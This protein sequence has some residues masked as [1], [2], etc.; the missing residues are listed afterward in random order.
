MEIL[1]L[2][3][4]SGDAILIRF[5]DV[6]RV[7]RHILVDGGNRRSDY[8]D[9]L[10]REMEKIAGSGDAIDLLVATHQDQDHVKGLQ[11]L[12][13]DL[14][15]GQITGA[16]CS[17]IRRYWFNGPALL[18]RTLRD[19]GGSFEDISAAEARDLER[20]VLQDLKLGEADPRSLVHCPQEVDLHGA[21]LT[22]L[23]PD[24]KALTN[25]ASQYVDVA[26]KEPDH[27]EPL[28]T[29]I[30]RERE[31]VSTQLDRGVPNASS[32]A[33]LIE[34]DGGSALLMGDAV[35]GVVEPAIETLLAN[36][37]LSHLD[38]DVVKLSHHGSARSTSQHFLSLVRSTKFVVST[39]GSRHGLP[40]KTTLARILV[41]GRASD[42]EK[43]GF[44]FNQDG[45][46]ERLGLSAEEMRRHG[47]TTHVP[48]CDSGYRIEL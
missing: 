17:L 4:G 40:D 3:A 35:P 26:G 13:R 6:R 33:F 27:A 14:Q 20:Y 16:D 28:H 42:T 30:E 36:R 2:K 1:F 43:P 10:K 19:R 21:R 46:V 32:I 12:H 9:N 15:N 48:N 23:S 8:L 47:F 34:C 37:G 5:L 25:Y 44:Y 31:N 7:P 29:L 45:V 39:D 41:H 18:K 24:G 22:V 11:W 38:V